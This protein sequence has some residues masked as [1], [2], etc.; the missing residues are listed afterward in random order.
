[1]KLLSS[2]FKKIQLSQ[3]TPTLF[4]IFISLYAVFLLLGAYYF[5]TTITIIIILPFI[6]ISAYR[7]EVIG[8]I[9]SSIWSVIL[10]IFSSVTHHHTLLQDL[11][12]KPILQW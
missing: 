11:K 2:L 4:T 12:H 8:G 7:W 9:L 5:L 6:M 3:V 1:M 10:V